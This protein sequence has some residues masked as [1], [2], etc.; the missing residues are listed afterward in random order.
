MFIM[1]RYVDYTVVNTVFLIWVKSYRIVYIN[2]KRIC[3][4]L[5]IVV[6]P[7]YVIYKSRNR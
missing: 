4:N 5:I 3:F 2:A 7:L 6:N 1:K